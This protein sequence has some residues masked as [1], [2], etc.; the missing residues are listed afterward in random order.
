M[1]LIALKE[2]YMVLSFVFTYVG[3][4]YGG[5]TEGACTRPYELAV[6]V[7]DVWSGVEIAI[8]CE[9]DVPR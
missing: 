1:V 7:V 9:E 8:G 4:V 5:G 3:V 6:V 2:T